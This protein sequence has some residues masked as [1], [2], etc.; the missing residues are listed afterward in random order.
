MNRVSSMIDT[1]LG[2]NLY[3]LSIQT[4]SISYIDYNSHSRQPAVD[5]ENQDYQ[6]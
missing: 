1:K 4:A 2:E 6:N 3:F 5:G